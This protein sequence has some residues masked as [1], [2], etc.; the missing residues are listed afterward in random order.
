MF[1]RKAPENYLESRAEGG[2]FLGN[3]RIKD[4]NRNSLSVTHAGTLPM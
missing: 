2:R 3:A 1:L 4:T